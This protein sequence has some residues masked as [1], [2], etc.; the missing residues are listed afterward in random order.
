MAGSRKIP[1]HVD[2]RI[3]LFHIHWTRYFYLVPLAVLCFAVFIQSP[4]PTKLFVGIFVVFIPAL[5]S[6]E[7]FQKESGFQFFKKMLVYLRRGTIHYERSTQN[8]ESFQKT[9]YFKKR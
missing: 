4:S 5:F 8:V 9:S 2:S 3:M 7:F 1:R 6:M